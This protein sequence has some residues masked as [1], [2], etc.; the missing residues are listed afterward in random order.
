VN[1]RRRRFTRRS[2]RLH[3]MLRSWPQLNIERGGGAVAGIV[4][5]PSVSAAIAAGFE[6]YD[7]TPEGY[8][9]RT[10]TARGWAL[11]LVRVRR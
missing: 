11:A 7:R 6:V 4:V 1:R 9:V 3:R 8:L 10:K 5:F 2:P